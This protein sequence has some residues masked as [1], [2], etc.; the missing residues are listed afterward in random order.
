M[1]IMHCFVFGIGANHFMSWRTA[2]LMDKKGSRRCLTLFLSLIKENA[3]QKLYCFCTKKMEKRETTAFSV[4]VLE[5]TAGE[6]FQ[7]F[8]IYQQH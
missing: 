3:S 5:Q 1:D 6:K 4:L 7:I 2:L 8:F